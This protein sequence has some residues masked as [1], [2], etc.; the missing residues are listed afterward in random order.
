[1]ELIYTILSSF[2]DPDQV[3]YCKKKSNIH[4]NEDS[5]IS[6]TDDI[7]ECLWSEPSLL[8]LDGKFTVVGDIHGNLTDLLRIFEKIGYPPH[9]NYLFL[10][11]YVDRGDNSLEVITLLFCLKLLYPSHIYL[12]RGNHE[13]E[14]ISSFYGFKRE[15]LAN[16]SLKIYNAFT[17]AFKY[18]PFAAV[19]ND[20]I[21]CVHGGIGPSV[22]LQKI[23]D[24]S[25][26]MLA[27]D[28]KLTEDLVWS[29]PNPTVDDFELSDRGS[30]SI[31]GPEQVKTFFK[32]NKLVKLIRSHEMANEGY[33]EVFKNCYT[34]F[35]N[36]NYCG[37][38]NSS[39]VANV[40]NIQITFE[41]F[42]PLSK[43]ELSK[44]RVILPDFILEWL[45]SDDEKSQVYSPPE[46]LEDL[47]SFL[48]L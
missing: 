4:L 1:M 25:R 18:L 28:S 48:Q 40:E 13:C 26:P 46:L 2:K 23:S 14:S 35:S 39:A 12:L 9:K 38:G 30:G 16:Y 6:L 45:D 8:K 20:S 42:Q 36:T 31:Y 43:K 19:L 22:S 17:N 5:L 27:S 7:C 10:G 44:R 37:I 32:D 11:D 15:V 3:L 33:T 24:L 34:V 47:P 21:F 41:T 29:D